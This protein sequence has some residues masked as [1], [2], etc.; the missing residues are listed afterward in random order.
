M[1][2]GMSGS[3]SHTGAL[4]RGYAPQMAHQ[5]VADGA[6]EGMDDFDADEH[7]SGDPADEQEDTSTPHDATTAQMGRK[8]AR[9]HS[10]PNAEGDSVRKAE[11]E[12]VSVA[13]DAGAQDKDETDKVKANRDRNR[14]HARNTRLRKKAY[15]E[16][17]KHTVQ[18]LST[19]VC[20]CVPALRGFC[21]ACQ[22][23]F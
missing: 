2:T 11:K 14:E 8:R 6:H 20:A 17:L 19:E 4:L 23:N 22:M 13:T 3:A 21:F 7:T 18:E 1:P 5:P 16:R 12:S 15:V 9:N 10:D